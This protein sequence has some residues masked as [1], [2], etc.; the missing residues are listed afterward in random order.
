MAVFDV[1]LHRGE[2]DAVDDIFR[3]LSW[4]EEEEEINKYSVS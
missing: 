3:R 2:I 4:V 1:N